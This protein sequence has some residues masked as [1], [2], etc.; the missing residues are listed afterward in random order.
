MTAPVHRRRPSWLKWG[1]VDAVGA[2]AWAGLGV[3][4]VVAIAVWTLSQLGWLLLPAAIAV[5]FGVVA[6]PIVAT[7][8]RRGVRR[9]PATALVFVGLFL[10]GAG[11]VVLIVPPF[12][13]Q[14]AKLS[15]GIPEFIDRAAKA[16]RTFED[17]A[18]V[19]NPATAELL[20]ST[21]EALRNSADGVADRLSDA[22]FDWVGLTGTVLVAG[23][24]G[25]V[26]SFLAVVDLP[27]YSRPIRPWLDRPGN[28]RLAGVLEQMRRTATGFIRG[29]MLKALVVWALSAGAYAIAGVPYPIPLG[30]LTAVGTFIPTFGPLLAGIPAIVISLAAGGTSLAIAC[31]VAIFAVQL[32]EDYVLVPKIVGSAVEIPPLVVIVSLTLAAGFFGVVGLVLIVPGVAIARDLV[33]WMFM[34]DDEVRTNLAVLRAPPDDGGDG[35]SRPEGRRRRRDPGRK[36]GR[37]TSRKTSRKTVPSD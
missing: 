29:Q 25:V 3:V 37:K 5:I 4:A 1:Q 34:T 9:A 22:V 2:M 13:T 31:L 30:V 36:T 15:A 8:E 7:L 6:A 11:L 27:R 20:T 24:I 19:T 28:E 17:R 21:E 23:A 35:V 26:L 14:L 12:V 10:V 32:F 33:R 18:Q 16:L